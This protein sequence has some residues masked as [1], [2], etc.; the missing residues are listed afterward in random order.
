MGYAALVAV[1]VEAAA[2]D[3]AR[4]KKYVKARAGPEASQ[5]E[6]SDGRLNESNFELPVS[7]SVE[8]PCKK[9]D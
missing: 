5:V 8:K 6:E 1:D 4:E 9:F 3:L 7:R 2:D